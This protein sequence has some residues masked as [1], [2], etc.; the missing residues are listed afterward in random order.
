MARPR[1]YTSHIEDGIEVYRE[2]VVRPTPVHPDIFV[3]AHLDTVN[4]DRRIHLDAR[5]EEVTADE[6]RAI[7]AA[8][9]DLVDRL[10]EL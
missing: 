10:G 6:A 7:A 9:L 8:L 5:M 3:A 2:I 4:G 1:T